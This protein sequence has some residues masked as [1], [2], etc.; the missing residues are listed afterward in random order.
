MLIYV[1]AITHYALVN[2]DPYIDGVSNSFTDISNPVY[3]TDVKMSLPYHKFPAQVINNGTSNILT[4]DLPIGTSMCLFLQFIAPTLQCRN[5]VIDTSDLLASIDTRFIQKGFAQTTFDILSNATIYNFVVSNQYDWE[6]LRESFPTWYVNLTHPILFD[7]ICEGCRSTPDWASFL[8]IGTAETVFNFGLWGAMKYRDVHARTFM[9]SLNTALTGGASN[10]VL[11]QPAPPPSSP[12]LSPQTLMDVE[13][14]PELSEAFE[15]TPLTAELTG[16]AASGIAGGTIGMS[17]STA[18]Q[19]AASAL[20]VAGVGSLG[21][22]TSALAGVT[23]VPVGVVTPTIV[24]TTRLVAERVSTRVRN[25]ITDLREAEA[26]TRWE[27]HEAYGQ[28]IASRVRPH[29]P[30]V[31]RGIEPSVSHIPTNVHQVAITAGASVASSAAISVVPAM[32]S[33]A[34]TLPGTLLAIMPKLRRRRSPLKSPDKVHKVYA[35]SKTPPKTPQAPVKQTTTPLSSSPSPTTPAPTTPSTMSKPITQPTTPTPPTTPAVAT[36][37]LPGG[38]SGSHPT[39][40]RRQLGF[41]WNLITK[42]PSW[43]YPTISS[44]VGWAGLGGNLVTH[45]T[46]RKIMYPITYVSRTERYYVAITSILLSS[47]FHMYPEEMLAEINAGKPVI[48]VSGIKY[49]H[50]DI[51]FD[52]NTM[53]PGDVLHRCSP[54]MKTRFLGV[55]RHA[56]ERSIFTLFDASILINGILYYSGP[57]KYIIMNYDVYFSEVFSRYKIH[58]RV[59]ESM[60]DATGNH[61]ELDFWYPR[62]PNVSFDDE[63]VHR[64][65]RDIPVETTTDVPDYS[66]EVTT[67]LK[68]LIHR[69]PAPSISETDVVRGGGVMLDTSVVRGHKSYI[70]QPIEYTNINWMQETELVSSLD[71]LMQTPAFRNEMDIQQSILYN[72]TV[73]YYRNLRH[74]M[75]NAKLNTPLVLHRNVYQVPKGITLRTILR[76]LNPWDFSYPRLLIMRELLNGYQPTKH[77]TDVVAR[78]RTYDSELKYMNLT[79]LVA[80]FYSAAFPEDVD[81]PL[82]LS[83]GQVSQDDFQTVLEYIYTNSYSRVPVV[84]I[85]RDK[86]DIKRFSDNFLAPIRNTRDPYSWRYYSPFMATTELFW[87]DRASYSLCISRRRNRRTL[88]RGKFAGLSVI[89]NTKDAEFENRCSTASLHVKYDVDITSLASNP[90]IPPRILTQIASSGPSTEWMQELSSSVYD[91]GLSELL[92]AVDSLRDPGSDES[93]FYGEG[94]HLYPSVTHVVTAKPNATSAGGELVPESPRRERPRYSKLVKQPDE[95]VEVEY[96]NDMSPNPLSTIAAAAAVVGACAFPCC[97]FLLVLSFVRRPLRPRIT[98]TSRPSSNEYVGAS[99][100]VPVPEH[101]RSLVPLLENSAA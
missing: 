4:V 69:E 39:R 93:A 46:E 75:E 56:M 90:F 70:R 34:I 30:Y 67:P 8:G 44:A 95:T 47:C 21:I 2:K 16:S 79:T 64:R 10:V 17:L 61:M 31:G 96:I 22:S 77:L 99:T 32:T 29:L 41:V 94:G 13:L 71:Q 73:S 87:L 12:S 53:S 57:P 92:T 1:V 50:S 66:E 5:Q 28:K 3:V 68:S 23:G 51:V 97:V 85:M 26:G 6:Y 24:P 11:P 37:K 80:M 86:R 43:V 52:F 100:V 74:Y 38:K 27:I 78:A 59:A 91:P 88:K 14:S 45:S 98:S 42:I 83:S 72:S 60:S 15:L 76:S 54:L 7:T 18:A 65:R 25:T 40:I 55:P 9:H 58:S 35:T 20:P 48:E 19:I 82:A 63:K 81:G 62:A 49:H 89:G 36:G 84:F 33:S 101:G